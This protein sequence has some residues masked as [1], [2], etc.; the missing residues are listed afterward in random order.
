M[1]P[2]NWRK[3]EKDSNDIWHALF[4]KFHLHVSRYKKR[5]P[6]CVSTFAQWYYQVTYPLQCYFL[7]LSRF[8]RAGIY[9]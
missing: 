3:K 1:N 7:L 9:R 8:S 6:V 5:Q 4:D 2:R